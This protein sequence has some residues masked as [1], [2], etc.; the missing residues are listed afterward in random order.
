M[1]TVER[2]DLAALPEIV[3]LLDSA[4][5]PAGGLG[6]DTATI[7]LTASGDE[8]LVGAAAIERYESDGLLRS[9]VVAR[10]RRGTGIGRKLVAAAEAAARDVGIG[11]LFLLTEGAGPFFARLGYRPIDRTQVAP[12]VQ[13]SGE[14]SVLCPVDALTMV[15]RLGA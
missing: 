15:K 4:G 5:L 3:V 13:A 7:V 1:V 12:A 11:S 14:Y 10:S 6:D 8:G 9:V 2:S